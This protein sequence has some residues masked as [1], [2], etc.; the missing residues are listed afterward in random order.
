MAPLAAVEHHLRNFL[1]SQIRKLRQ[2]FHAEGRTAN[3]QRTLL[4]HLVTQF[5][6]LLAVQRLRGYVD[7]VFFR[8]VTLIPVFRLARGVGKTLQLAH[9]FREHGG[10]VLLADDPVAEL[11]LLQQGGRDAV[12][13]KS[14]APFPIHG[15]RDSTGVS[16]V[17]SFFETGNDKSI[18]MLSKFYH[19]PTAPHLL[20]NCTS[21]TRTSERV[22]DQ[23]ARVASDGQYSMNQSFGLWCIEGIRFSKKTLDF[24]LGLVGMTNF[25]VWPPRPRNDAINIF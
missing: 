14:A 25:F 12:V 11:V 5:F 19:D 9:C 13:A 8:G 15:F 22:E 4:A 16:N 24:S 23:V 21:R 3:Q 2:V 17:D 1:Y 7:E 6:Q 18:A 20:G 10:V